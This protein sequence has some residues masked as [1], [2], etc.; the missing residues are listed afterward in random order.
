[1]DIRIHQQFGQIGLNIKEPF[2][3]LKISPPRLELDIREAKLNIHSEL[4]KISIDQTECFADMDRRTLSQLLRYLEELAW[5]AGLEGI[6]KIAQEGDML[7]AIEDGITVGDIAFMN[8]PQPV[9]F[10]VDCIPKHRPRIEFELHPV[11]YQLNRGQVGVNLVRG[12]VRLNLD[13][14]KVQVYLRQWPWLEI[15]YVGKYCN[16][17]A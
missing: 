14:G 16:T 12:D 15:E 11:E 2:L 17:V 7:G 5:E 8:N 3:H 4:P 9:D 6:G 13:W 10:N 1:M